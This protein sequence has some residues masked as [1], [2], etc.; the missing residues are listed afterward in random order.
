MKEK[1]MNKV[2][3]PLP[4]MCPRWKSADL[5]RATLLLVFVAAITVFTFGELRTADVTKFQISYPPAASAGPVTGRLILILAT[6]GEPEPRLTVGPNGPALFG[7]DLDQLQPNQ[8]VTVDQTTLG[9]PKPLADLPPGGYFA[10]AIINVYTQVHRSDGHTLW[11]HLNDGMQEVFNNAS[12]NL[13]SQVQKVHIGS[14]GTFSLAVDRVIPPAQVAADTE[15]VK[16]VRIRS[17]KLSAFWGHPIY[18]NA[19]VLLPKGYADH[20]DAHY[21]T[22][23]TMGH[24]VP[25]TFDPKPGPSP[26]EQQMEERGLES[27]HQFYQSWTGD[28][29]PR[30]IAVS[31]QQQTPFF[32]DSYSVNSV[33]QGPYG[34]AMI[35]E[36][37]PYL[38][39]HFRMIAKPYARLVEGASTGGWQTLALQ[40]YHPDFF[41]GAWVLQP[42]P[43]SFRHYQMV[44]AYQDA[45]AFSVPSGPFTTAVRPMRRSTEGQVTITVHDLSLFEAVLGSRGRSGYQFEAWEAIYGP[46]GADGYPIPLWNK[47]TGQIDHTVADYMRD[48][49]YDLLEYTKRNWTMLGPKIVGKL[50]FFC[51]DMDNFYLNLAVYDYQAFLKTTAGPHYEAAFTFGRPMKGH[52][53]HAFT[54][55]EMVNRMANQVRGNA[56]AGD[57]SSSWN[58]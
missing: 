47:E 26:T 42:D 35:E 33:N 32:P 54:W 21:P 27:G 4:D 34:D 22:V 17:E 29:F 45:N 48:H 11:V 1:V 57:D 14:G 7:L 49:G 31:F 55:A 5:F 25:F 37:I 6:K 30:M 46:I 20:P 44:N 18:I 10:Q 41:G 3:Q 16:H 58:Y 15:W 23:Y 39:S 8:S 28:R 53:W 51:G 43:I 12:G 9:F 24:E 2:E 52:G 40:L 13:Y 19:T 56:P 50:H 38:E 36:V